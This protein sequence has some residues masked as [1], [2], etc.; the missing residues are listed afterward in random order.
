MRIRDRALFL[1]ARP[2]AEHAAVV[3]LLTEQR[4]LVAAYVNGARSKKMR[5]ILAPGNLLFAELDRRGGGDLWT[6]RIEADRIY[7]GLSQS[8]LSLAIVA[9][10]GALLSDVLP[11]DE[12]HP[13]LFEQ[14]AACCELL[15]AGAD[16]LSAGRALAEFELSLLTELGFRL[17]LTACAV[18]GETERLAFLSPK[19]GRAVTQEGAGPYRERLFP[20]PAFFLDRAEPADADDVVAGLRITR[21]FL[22]RDLVPDVRAER[23]DA[24]RQQID[25]RLDRLL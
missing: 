16:A 4:G 13:L 20:L 14:W 5:G 9:W 19:S 15:E 6:A 8:G 1:S 12:P 10:L 18:T 22:M 11:E 21:H 25:A 3:R 7:H 2:H 23:L 24:L 17:D